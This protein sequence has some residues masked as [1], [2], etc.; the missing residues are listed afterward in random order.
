[1]IKETNLVEQLLHEFG[2]LIGGPD[3]VK[4]LG[5]RSNASFKRA[6]KLGQIDL[7]MFCIEGRKGRFAY[8]QKVANWLSKLSDKKSDIEQSK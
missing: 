3:L 5:F 6:E 4:V 7:E 1:M 8:T 2:P